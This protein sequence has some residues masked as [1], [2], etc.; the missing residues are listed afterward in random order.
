MVFHEIQESLVLMKDEFIFGVMLI[1][2][3]CNIF[4]HYVICNVSV[5]S[6]LVLH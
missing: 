6:S 3:E 5:L 2:H 4:W 1:V